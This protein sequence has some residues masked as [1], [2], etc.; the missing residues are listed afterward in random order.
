MHVYT[1]K[2]RE[3]NGRPP[4]DAE[5]CKGVTGAGTSRGHK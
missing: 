5:E 3:E 2:V 1:L 4:D